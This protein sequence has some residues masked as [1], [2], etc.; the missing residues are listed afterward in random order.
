MNRKQRRALKRK[1]L[2]SDVQEKISLFGMLPSQCTACLK[3][4]NKKDRE[5][6]A[7]WNVVVREKEKE[8]NLYCPMCWNAAIKIVE[9]IQ[10]DD[11]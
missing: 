1:E 7:T 5:M 4:F 9:E 2:K 11:R 10:N 3:S 6:V 8:V